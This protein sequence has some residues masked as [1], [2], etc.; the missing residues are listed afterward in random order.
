[1]HWH[2]ET[3]FSAHTAFPRLIF[4][5]WPLS[6]QCIICVGLPQ[7]LYNKCAE[8]ESKDQSSDFYIPSFLLWSAPSR[9]TTHYCLLFIASFG[10]KLGPSDIK[11]TSFLSLSIS[12]SVSVS[13]S[14]LLE[15]SFAQPQDFPLLLPPDFHSSRFLPAHEA[16]SHACL[17]FK[18]LSL[19]NL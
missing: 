1:M 14:L 9:S 16:A 7:D 10:L 19:G 17:T 5:V 12:V 6:G 2:A 15:A 18:I 3:F 4:T 11:I 8:R 13:V